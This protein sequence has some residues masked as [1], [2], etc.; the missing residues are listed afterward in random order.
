MPVAPRWSSG[1]PRILLALVLEFDSHR[2]GEILTL[3]AK[4]GKKGS[5]AENG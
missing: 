4:M 3:F 5:T 1:S 2:G